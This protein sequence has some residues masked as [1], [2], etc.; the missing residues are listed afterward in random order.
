MSRAANYFEW[1]S[2]LVL[3]E[4]GRRVI[5]IG[6]GIGNFTRNCSRVTPW[7]RSTLKRAASY[8]F[9]NAIRIN[10]TSTPSS[11]KQGPASTISRNS[12]PIQSFV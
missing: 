1:Q 5:E 11:G 9:A 4:L 7:S 6:C 2:R 12:A 10:P 3:P 8:V